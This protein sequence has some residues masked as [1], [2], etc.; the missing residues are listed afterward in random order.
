MGGVNLSVRIRADMF[1]SSFGVDGEQSLQVTN[2]CLEGSF[3]ETWKSWYL[4]LLDLSL[5]GGNQSI[6]CSLSGQFYVEVNCTVLKWTHM[7]S[8]LLNPFQLLI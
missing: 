3:M 6:F 7:A 8:L 1:G 4:A 5:V 2:A